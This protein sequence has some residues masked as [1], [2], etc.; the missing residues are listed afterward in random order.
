MQESKFTGSAWGLFG[1]NILIAISA[2]FLLIPLVFVIPKYYKWYYSHVVIDGKQLELDYDGPWWGIIGWVLFSVITLGIGSFYATKKIN[3]YFTKHTKVQGESES[4]SSFDG[5]AW[6]IF[7]WSLLVTLSVYLLLIPLVFFI[8][9]INKWIN[10]HTKISG[11]QL[12]FT[13]NGPWWGIL[14]WMLFSIITLGIG[15]YYAEK[16]RIQWSIGNTHFAD[17]A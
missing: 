2:Y 3:Q 8:G 12:I 14:G 10:N 11:K 7:G 4:E 9:K 6:G 17:Q 5:S 16:K 15:S 1:W 13:H